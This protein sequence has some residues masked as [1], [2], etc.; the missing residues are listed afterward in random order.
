MRLNIHQLEPHLKQPLLPVYLVTG[1]EPLQRGEAL[2]QLRHAARAQGHT[3][4]D[5]L[6]HTAHFDWN[7][8]AGM[9]DNLSLF[10]DK[11]LIELRLGSPKIGGDGSKALVAY[12][13]R[14][15][16]DTVLLITSPKLERNQ[17]SAKWVKALE[18]AGALVTVWPIE[19]NQLPGWLELR[20][21]TRGLQPAPGVA[22]WLAERVEGNL[23]A[24]AQEVEKLLLLQSPGSLD[25]T[26][27]RAAVSDSARYTVFDLADSALEGNTARCIRVL[28]T[29]QGEG[30]PDALAL[31][32]LTKETRLLASLAG[33]IKAGRSASQAIAAR[34]E[35]WDKRRP[36]YIKAL[37]RQPVQGWRRLLSLCARADRAVKGVDNTDPW[38]LLEDIALGMTGHPDFVNRYHDQV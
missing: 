14:P 31:W 37:K 35:I 11:R 2:D 8:L 17:L 38:L 6:E 33:D 5:V 10:G 26:Q 22:A 21:K 23:L 28:Q 9:A 27:L 3:E 7:Q 32:A 18:Q 1:D 20:M 13:E 24:A 30:T 4:R 25:M 12:S 19:R 16:E 36:L 15:P 29:L 34:R